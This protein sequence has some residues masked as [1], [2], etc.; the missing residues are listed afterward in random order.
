MVG[1]EEP[2][3]RESDPGMVAQQLISTRV[4]DAAQLA[5]V[6]LG[7]KNLEREILRLFDAQAAELLDRIGSEEPGNIAGLAHRLLGSARGVG[8]LAVAAAAEALGEAASGGNEAEVTIAL[9]RVAG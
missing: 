3:E 9:G 5:G 1:A 7:D 6:T 4:I 8:A 2:P